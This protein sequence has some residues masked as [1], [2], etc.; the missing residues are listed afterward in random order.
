MFNNPCIL[1]NNA[2]IDLN[3]RN[4]FNA[5]F[6]KVNELPQ[7]TSHITAKL[8]VDNSRD[9]PSLVRNNQDND[10]NIRNLTNINSITLDTQ[11]VN[12]NQ[13]ITKAY[14]DQFHS[15]NERTGRDL[16]LE[17]YEESTDLVKNNQENDLNDK[18]L[19]N[20]VSLTVNRNPS[21]DNE[22]V[23]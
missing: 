12:D 10:F 23:N 4:I 17:L 16:G 9:E 14:V 8:Y 21:S 5:R 7:I 2:Q 3:G 20:I 18:K 11:A 19:T 6:I 1:K 22:L 13:V 15:D